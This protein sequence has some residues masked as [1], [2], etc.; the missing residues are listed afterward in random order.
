[1]NNA[2]LHHYL[3]QL[4]KE[5]IDIKDDR[6]FMVRSGFY[7]YDGELGMV[8]VI[9]KEDPA[10]VKIRKERII[11]KKVVYLRKKMPEYFSN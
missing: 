9:L 3:K 11:K 4:Y 1:M 2:V 7:E 6:E 8:P 10:E 5:L